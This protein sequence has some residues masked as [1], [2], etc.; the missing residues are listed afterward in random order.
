MLSPTSTHTHTSSLS[1][2]MEGD[3]IV[4]LEVL[5]LEVKDGFVRIDPFLN[6]RIWH[7]S[8]Q[9]GRQSDSSSWMERRSK[10]VNQR[11]KTVFS[12][13]SRRKVLHWFTFKSIQTI[14]MAGSVSLFYPHPRPCLNRKPITHEAWRH[15]RDGFI[16]SNTII[17]N[18]RQVTWEKALERSWG[19]LHF[20][21]KICTTGYLWMVKKK[22]SKNKE[23]SL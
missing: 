7:P 6:F 9:R 19:K 10:A 23:D 2:K 18:L 15:R 8:A 11:N 17:R 14:H 22:S 12:D 21:A 5:S 3:K 13:Q 16:C 1:V 4:S 20:G